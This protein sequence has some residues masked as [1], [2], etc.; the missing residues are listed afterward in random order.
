MEPIDVIRKKESFSYDY[1]MC[2]SDYDKDALVEELN[3]MK[4]EFPHPEKT[5]IENLSKKRYEYLKIQEDSWNEDIL[6]Y[7]NEPKEINELAD[8]I[9]KCIQQWREELS[10]E[11]IF[12]E[13]TK[14]GWAPCLLYDDNGNFAVSGEGMQG[15]NPDG[16]DNCEMIH[17]VEK[18]KWKP[19]IREALYHYLDDDE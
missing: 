18:D 9:L 3:R 10:F 4:K 5:H 15:I 11:F 6:D 7:E 19:T 14:L 2:E 8:E 1:T 16:A 17:F 12:E 13:L